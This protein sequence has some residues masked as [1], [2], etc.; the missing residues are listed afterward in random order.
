MEEMDVII[1]DSTTEQQ[2][3]T[4]YCNSTINQIEYF[5]CIECKRTVH[6][7]CV[8]SPPPGGLVGDVF[9]EFTCKICGQGVEEYTRQR[10]PW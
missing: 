1:T 3:R 10:L 8:S 6:L 9:F 7:S 2:P 5:T 4:C